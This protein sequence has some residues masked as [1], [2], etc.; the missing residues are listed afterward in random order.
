[1]FACMACA[2]GI[3][4]R[5]K[6]YARRLSL[7]CISPKE[8]ETMSAIQPVPKYSC[9]VLNLFFCSFVADVNHSASPR[10]A[11]GS[12]TMAL[13]S[14]PPPSQTQ[15]AVLLPRQVRFR[16]SL[17]GSRRAR[18]QLSGSCRGARN[19]AITGYRCGIVRRQ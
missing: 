6:K 14:P 17:P 19:L 2:V 1:M 3:L 18:G 10:F 11:F 4:L 12:S 5:I 7:H 15:Q 8:F 16:R 9:C 13:T